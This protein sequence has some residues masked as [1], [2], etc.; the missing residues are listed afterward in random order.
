MDRRN[1]WAAVAAASVLT[2]VAVLAISGT[3]RAQLDTV[4][5]AT[6]S[7]RWGAVADTYVIAERPAATPGTES[8]L[9]AAQWPD[10]HTRAYVRFRVGE[11]RTD[12]PI[13]SV[14]V[15]FTFQRTQ[16]QP[17]LTELRTVPSNSWSE[18]T[19]SYQN[20]PATGDVVA[21]AG[22]PAGA[23]TVSFDVTRQVRAAGSYSFA[24]VNR[25][26]DSGFVVNSREYGSG[27]P[28]LT[29]T[30]GAA[31]S[32]SPTASPSGAPT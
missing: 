32:A 7:Q 30:Y 18:S 5:A 31:P 8:K 13:V 3:P 29:V 26:A 11:L 23:S 10:W 21:T 24:V 2:V 6:T 9:T 12:L 14:T 20:R 28:R 27:V 19:T 15:R 25:T 22:D 16:S 4:D 1:S 17:R